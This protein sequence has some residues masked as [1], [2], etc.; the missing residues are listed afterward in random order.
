MSDFGSAIMCVITV[1]DCYVLV[2]SFGG[3]YLDFQLVKENYFSC[4]Y[5]V[6]LIREK[7]T[8]CGGHIGLQY[9]RQ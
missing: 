3:Y 5:I 1:I 8:L 4:I 7:Q 6:G 2:N 9:G